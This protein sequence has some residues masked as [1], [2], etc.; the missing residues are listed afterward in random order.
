MWSMWL[1][2]AIDEIP[3]DPITK[4]EIRSSIPNMTVGKAP[5]VCG[6][7]VELLNAEM[8]TLVDT[9]HDYFCEVWVYEAVPADIWKNIVVRI[10]RNG[11]ITECG[12]CRDIT[13]MSVA[14]KC[15][16]KC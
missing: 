16:A 2:S 3:S 10:A 14:T 1:G 13:V 8:A 7:K 11:D 15:W 9:L 12:N 5:G 6:I 4:V